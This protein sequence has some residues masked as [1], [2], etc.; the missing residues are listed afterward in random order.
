MG[1]KGLL[2]WASKTWWERSEIAQALYNMFNHSLFFAP[3][4]CISKE[5]QRRD[6]KMK[7]DWGAVTGRHCQHTL[8]RLRGPTSP[9]SSMMSSWVTEV[10]RF[11]MTTLVPWIGKEGMMQ[12]CIHVHQTV[13]TTEFSYNRCYRYFYPSKFF[14]FNAILTFIIFHLFPWVF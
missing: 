13:N 3:T 5:L 9:K 4:Y 1:S 2:H 7:T 12:G 11:V 8:A 10:C 6:M 14:T